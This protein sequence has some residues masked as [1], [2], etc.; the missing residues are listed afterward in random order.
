MSGKSSSDISD[1]G[2]DRTF[3]KV[4]TLQKKYGKTGSI[5]CE[6]GALYI[7]DFDEFGVKTGLGHMEIPNGST[8]DGTFNKGLPNGVGVM[9]FPDS[10]RY[11][12]EFMQGWF[13]GHGVYS[14]IDGMKYEGEFRGGKIWGNGLMTY[15]DGTPSSEGYFQ[16]TK[17]R[18]IKLY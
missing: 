8:Y 2:S 10:S 4:V 5:K 17:F 12:G 11:E 3:Q 15:S 9:R 14:T 6:N 18:S 1:D 7:G 13:H 16:E